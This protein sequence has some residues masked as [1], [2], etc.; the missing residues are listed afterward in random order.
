V[1]LW[2]LAAGTHAELARDAPARLAS[3]AGGGA[4][5]LTAG[6]GERVEVRDGASG[7]VLREFTWQADRGAADVVCMA[8]SRERVVVGCADHYLRFF[9]PATGRSARPAL[10]TIALR[11]VR[12]VG[13]RVLV[14]GLGGGGSV[15]AL[16]LDSGVRPDDAVHPTIYHEGLITSIGLDPTGAL[17]L[18]SSEDGS[19]FVWD[20][21]SGAVR[22]WYTLHD[23]RLMC[24]AFSPVA[25]DRRVL[26]V[27]SDGSAAVWPI[28]PERA[29][30]LR[31]GRALDA[32]ERAKELGE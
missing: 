15:R 3:F 21:E 7:A 14:A 24:A 19:A 29:A 30:L 9:D 13:E 31:R 22:S 11:W 1:R 10:Y 4:L 25:D 26:S 16:E 32:W 12:A 6:A 20:A 23:G 2:D 18:T 5:L 27:A 17:A 28:E 8:V